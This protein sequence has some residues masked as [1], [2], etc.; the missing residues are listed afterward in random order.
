MKVIPET[1]R[2]H[3]IRYICFCYQEMY[4]Q[5]ANLMRYDYIPS[6]D[7]ISG[8]GLLTEVHDFSEGKYNQTCIKRSPLGQGESG[9]IRQVTS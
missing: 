3:L 7:T 5:G 2:V 6:K 1:S 4:D 9:L 8:Y